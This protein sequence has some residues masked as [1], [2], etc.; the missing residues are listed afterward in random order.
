M[1]A[2]SVLD[3]PEHGA[4]LRVGRGSRGTFNLDTQRASGVVSA[5]A[6]RS[7]KD[8]VRAV[9]VLPDPHTGFDEM[10]TQR[11]GWDSAATSAG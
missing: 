10:R 5:E 7:V 1:A 6:A 3:G 8:R 9:V 2:R 4:K 11:A